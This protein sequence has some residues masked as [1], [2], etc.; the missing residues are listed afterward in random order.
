L[1][2][3]VNSIAINY[4][5]MIWMDTQSYSNVIDSWIING[6]QLAVLLPNQCNQS[7]QKEYF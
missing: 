4:T 1:S 3:R 6:S 7:I 5:K 2:L